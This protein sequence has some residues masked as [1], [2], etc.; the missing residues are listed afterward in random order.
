MTGDKKHTDVMHVL[1]SN[2][3][4]ME[5]AVVCTDNFNI[6]SLTCCAYNTLRIESRVGTGMQV[7]I[8]SSEQTHLSMHGTVAL[9]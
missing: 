9:L 7:S 1:R 3:P 8:T 6:S 2:V 4:N 5:S